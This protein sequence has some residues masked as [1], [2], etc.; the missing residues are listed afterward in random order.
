MSLFE[1]LDDL[2][3]ENPVLDINVSF[4]VLQYDL[5]TLVKNIENGSFSDIKIQSII[6]YNL[7]DILDYT[8]FEKV[9]TR[10]LMQDLWTS[11]RFL[12][13]FLAVFSSDN[14]IANTIILVYRKELNKLI[15]D[16]VFINTDKDPDIESLYT[17]I[18]KLLNAKDII[19]LTTILP[20]NLAW[21]LCVCRYSSFKIDLCVHNLNFAII[22]SDIDISVKNIIYVYS[23]FY[24]DDFST[25]FC[26]TMIDVYG[27]EPKSDN[28]KRLND[29]ITVAILSILNSMTSMD[30]ELVLTRYA[31]Y[32]SFGK[33]ENRRCQIRGLSE[34]YA[35][36][37]KVVYSLEN[38][39]ICVP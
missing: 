5:E 6:K 8:N 31:N 11:K 34:D 15:F 30:I 29:R 23:R 33:Y 25:L 16:Y 12:N 2:H 17:M 20:R 3:D 19:P 35:R 21:Q 9:D 26:A 38:K 18:A 4:S 22:N 32:L 37:N 27:D 36:I 10:K 1:S 7:K 28:A 39:G 13:A 24:A 14:V